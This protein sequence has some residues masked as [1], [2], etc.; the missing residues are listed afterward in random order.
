MKSVRPREVA[1]AIVVAAVAV[2]LVSS[3]RAEAQYQTQLA[4][5]G[6]TGTDQRGVR[7][8]AFTVAPSV[9][10]APAN[11]AS[12]SIGANITRFGNDA[13][14]LGA[15]GAFSGRDDIAGHI[16]FT[17]DVSANASRLQGQGKAGASF[18]SG[19]L[20][21]ALQVDAGPLTLFGGARAASGYASQ[22]AASQPLPVFNGGVRTQSQTRSGLGPTFGVTFTAVSEEDGTLRLGARQDLLRVSGVAVA[23]RA[24]LA[25]VGSRGLAVTGSVGQRSASDEHVSFG[26]VALSVAL[27]P[28]LAFDVAAGRYPSNRLSGT[29]G[30]NF[31]NAGLSWRFGGSQSPRS[32][33][34]VRGAARVAPGYTRLT[35]DAPDAA[36]VDVAG[37][38]NEWT[39]VPAR[40]A[41]AGVWYADLHI[42]P[43]QYRYAFR[44]NGKEWRVPRGATAVEDGFGGKSTW[45]TVGE[46]AK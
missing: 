23:D 14:S 3:R 29:L 13:L 10:F 21:P 20:L 12:L 40:R 11:G 43:G 9:S 45:L 38:F 7:S 19:E 35:I 22:S 4:V 44:V 27:R 2:A 8:S 31:V 30:G 33:S 15:G 16:A 46:P 36:R 37:D 17:L 42:A 5:S 24:L 34:P 32:A 1:K 41:A 39:P 26:S 28:D 25:S 18:A 6:G